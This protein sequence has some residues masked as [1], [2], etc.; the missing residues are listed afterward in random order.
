[1]NDREG[2]KRIL[3]LAAIA[4]VLVCAIL[5]ISLAA[6]ESPGSDANDL[7]ITPGGESG[8]VAQLD[9]DDGA[10]GASEPAGFSL[11]AGGTV[12]LVWR[13]GL[14]VLVI[15]GAVVG[16]RWWGRKAMAPRSTSGFLRIVDTLAIS[17]GRTIHLVALGDRVIVVGATAQQLAY[18]NELTADESDDV[19]SRLVR[20][21]QASSLGGFASELFQSLRKENQRSST[22]AAQVVGER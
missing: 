7:R 5:F 18:L 9:A 8:A 15:A 20:D 4:G 19:L 14:V 6:P 12:S 17:N 3:W 16:L 2:R 13:L 1:L 21:E 11:S 10:E 22:Q